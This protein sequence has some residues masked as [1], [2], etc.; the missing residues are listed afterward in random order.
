MREQTIKNLMVEHNLPQHLA[1]QLVALDGN[2][3]EGKL[4]VALSGISWGKN[5]AS[6][7]APGLVQAL[8]EALHE[9][10]ARKDLDSIMSLRS[11]LAKMGVP[12]P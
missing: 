8:T 5:P 4:A 2:V 6:S 10:Q 9:A 11:R 7:A 12:N 1:E 3:D